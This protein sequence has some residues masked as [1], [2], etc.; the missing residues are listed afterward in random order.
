MKTAAKP[1]SHFHPRL[2]LGHQRD[3]A[4]EPTSRFHPRLSLGHQRDHTV[5]VKAH[6]LDQ[7]ML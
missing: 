4:F 5:T 3:Q 6:L 2:S 1:I 7:D